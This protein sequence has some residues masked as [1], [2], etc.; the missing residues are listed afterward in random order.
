[1]YKLQVGS[2][3]QRLEDLHANPSGL[4]RTQWGGPYL[5]NPISNDPWQRE[6]KYG[7]D[8]VNDVVTISSD[9]PDGQAGTEDDVPDPANANG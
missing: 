9:G 3:P 5:D 7:A 2:Y 6:Y 1:M 4:T 8:E